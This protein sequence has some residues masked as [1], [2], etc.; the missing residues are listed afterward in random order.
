M[1]GGER[2][3][4]KEKKNVCLLSLSLS[5]SVVFCPSFFLSLSPSPSLFLS[6]PISLPFLNLFPS[7][8]QFSHSHLSSSQPV[9][10]SICSLLTDANPDDPL[11]PDI[12]NLYKTNRKEHDAKAKEWTRKY[13]C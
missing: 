2:E 13:A 6:L 7:L 12:A 5:L 8:T 10:L 9:L 1:N 11:V 3:R 4:D